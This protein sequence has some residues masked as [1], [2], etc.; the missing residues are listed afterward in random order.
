[1]RIWVELLAITQGSKNGP[2]IRVIVEE[3]RQS[4]K[5]SLLAAL[6][7]GVTRLVIGSGRF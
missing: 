1:M 6:L 5:F 4:D 2:T 3:T 7:A